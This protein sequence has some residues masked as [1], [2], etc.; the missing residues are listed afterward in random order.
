MLLIRYISRSRGIDILIKINTALNYYIN[1]FEF[2]KKGFYVVIIT[3]ILYY[4]IY[5]IFKFIIIRGFFY[6]NSDRG[7]FKLAGLG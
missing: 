3:I 6:L 7:P 1:S 5:F 2:K 4:F